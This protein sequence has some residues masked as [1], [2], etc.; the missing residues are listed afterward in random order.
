MTAETMAEAL[1]I[2][3][4]FTF[5][6]VAALD[7]MGADPTVAAA[8]RIWHWIERNQLARFTIRDAHN[9]LRGTFPRVKQLHDPLAALEERGYVEVCN[10]PPN[11][12]GRPPSPTV[13]VRP[14]I[15]RG[16]R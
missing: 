10:P 11:G 13:Q 7:M 15:A 3:A 12:P 5:H 6:S 1:E 8:R 14:E 2:M 4:V 16:W 9:A